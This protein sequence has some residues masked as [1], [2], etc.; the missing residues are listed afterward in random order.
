MSTAEQLQVRSDDLPKRAAEAVAVM[1]SSKV[2]DWL[3]CQW[4]F[5]ARWILGLQG[6]PTPFI[7]FGNASDTTADA[8]LKSKMESATTW[9]TRDVIEYWSE[10][11]RLE[12][13][14][15]DDWIGEDPERLAD[16]GLDAIADWRDV[17]AKKVQPIETHRWWRLNMQGEYGGRWAI[18]GEVDSIAKLVREMHRPAVIADLKTSG[19]S[20]SASDLWELLQASLY[21]AAAEHTEALRGVDPNR[22][23]VH[24]IVRRASEAKTQFMERPVSKEQRQGALDLVTRARVQI[25]TAFETGC[26]LPNQGSMTCSRRYCPFWRECERE[27]H[28]RIAD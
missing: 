20:Y 27:N 17:V 2:R 9:D 28:I 6:E 14:D 8:V 16:I 11:W 10:A 22:F 4:K 1:T 3:S 25:M 12:A 21:T 15:V 23:Q 24:V 7:A 13:G 5:M 26:F 18:T 19:R